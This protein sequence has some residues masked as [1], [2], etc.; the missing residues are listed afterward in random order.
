MLPHNLLCSAQRA[1]PNYGRVWGK[2]TCHFDL[3]RGMGSKN[4]RISSLQPFWCGCPAP[5]KKKQRNPK[6]TMSGSEVMTIVILFHSS[7]FWDL[8]HFYLSVRTHVKKDFPHT[9]VLQPLSRTPAKDLYTS[10]C[11]LENENPR[12]RC[13]H[14]FY[15]FYPYGHCHIK[16][17]KS[18]NEFD[19]FY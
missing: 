9:M 11:L 14:F 2:I 1:R 12:A 13:R 19:K 10:C 3:H 6:F 5:K 15:R 17:E 16:I 8:K 18:H 4:T 7:S